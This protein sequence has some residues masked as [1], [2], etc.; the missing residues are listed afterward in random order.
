MINV[1]RTFL[2]DPDEYMRILK[3]AWDKRWI[4]NNGELL[5]ELE[6][7]LKSFLGLDHFLFCG[8]GTI[9][10][11]MA[12]KAIG[13]SGDVITTPFSYVATTNAII[14]EQFRPLFVDIHSSDLN[15]DADKIE[16]SITENTVAILV[17]HVF[18][19][20][21]DIDKI[22]DIAKRYNLVVIYDG[23][24]AFGVKYRGRGLL[25]YGDFATCSF[26]ATKLFHT[27]EGGSISVNHEKWREK[28]Y[29]FRQF[30]HIYDE[31]FSEGVNGKNS[32]F[33]AAMGLSILPHM[34]EIMTARKEISEA[35]DHGLAGLNISKPIPREG[36][37][38]NNGYYPVLFESEEKLLQVAEALKSKQISGRRYFYP[39][40]NELPYLQEKQP[41]PVSEDL[42]RRV[43]CLPLYPGLDKESIDII[44]NTIHETIAKS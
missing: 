35:Y 40:L 1:T 34:E 18:G 20:P 17:T 10:L 31:Y 41:C 2:P 23:A 19:N 39:S 27:V 13:K 14:W 24:H 33:H 37:E 12:L 25:S 6:E 38:P 43:Y 15:V 4:T 16:A 7:K 42:S 22:E 11:Q 30:G 21:C 9:V 32:E 36:T 8:N 28:I 5:Q 3:R 29:L 26:H 44:C